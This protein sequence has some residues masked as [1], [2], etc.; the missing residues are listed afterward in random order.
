MF[1]RTDLQELFTLSDDSFG[2]DEDLPEEG[3]VNINVQARPHMEREGEANSKSD[4]RRQKVVGN[5]KSDRFWHESSRRASQS[6]AVDASRAEDGADSSQATSSNTFSR[7]NQLL[8]ALWEGDAISGV[9]DH[10]SLEPTTAVKLNADRLEK[11]ANRVVDEALANLQ[12]SVTVNSSHRENLSVER[13]TSGTSTSSSVGINRNEIVHSN[14]YQRVCG[15]HVEIS[16]NV[17]VGV[18][19]HGAGVDFS[20][21]ANNRF[22]R[23]GNAISSG[24]DASESS[25]SA[26]LQMVRQNLTGL[27][28]AT[29][30]SSNCSLNSDVDTST[31]AVAPTTHM[32]SSSFNRA[33]EAGARSTTGLKSTEATLLPRLLAVFRSGEAL[34]SDEILRRFGY[35]DD[36]YAVLFRETLRSVAKFEKGLWVKKRDFI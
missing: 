18:I 6:Q 20:S 5:R 32:G 27:R 17:G 2:V 25:S 24:A 15:N 30:V 28:A 13:C 21:G 12:N 31:S 8:K 22:Q 10:N 26:M 4:R 1:T 7:E 14:G 34:T 11:Y 9:Y 3:E 36:R 33:G 16:S 23:F 29:L 35:L 19:T